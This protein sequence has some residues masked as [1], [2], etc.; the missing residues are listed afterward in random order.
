MSDANDLEVLLLAFSFH[1]ARQMV[2][3]DA[4]TDAAELTWLDDRFPAHLL[5]QAGL[6]DDAGRDTDRFVELREA[7]LVELP[8]RLTLGEKLAVLESLL[9]A[10]AADGVLCPEELDTIR[11]A[12]DML[13]VAPDDWRPLLG[14][15][16]GSGRVR[17]G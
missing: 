13:G 8:E 17:P 2:T 12:G 14:D 11:S 16:L 4:E 5:T 1:M 7:A 10:L 15:L 9:E 6:V 3:A